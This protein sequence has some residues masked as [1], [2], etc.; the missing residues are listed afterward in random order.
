MAAHK[1][2]IRIP[3]KT[4]HTHTQRWR[5]WQ[6][7]T[8]THLLL[9]IACACAWVQNAVAS[10]KRDHQRATR[11][12]ASDSAQVGHA[13]ALTR[14]SSSQLVFQSMFKRLFICETQTPL[15]LS[16]TH[17]VLI[18]QPIDGDRH[19]KRILTAIFQSRLRD[20][21]RQ[22]AKRVPQVRLLHVHRKRSPLKTTTPRHPHA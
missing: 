12:E 2:A 9:S 7:W 1:Q 22:S 21:G 11:R 13:R 16:C 17:D 15:S 5:D 4:T 8:K 6:V 18:S 14:S 20:T 10:R 19:I 3:K